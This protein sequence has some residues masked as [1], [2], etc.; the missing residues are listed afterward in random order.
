MV[1]KIFYNVVFLLVFQRQSKWYTSTLSYV[2]FILNV[3]TGE[4]KRWSDEYS[5]IFL[6]DPQ[7]GLI[8]VIENE[9]K[10]TKKYCIFL[11]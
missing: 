8:D 11:F 5:F 6:A 7:P 4:N 10:G 9:G 1:L 3:N 2:Y